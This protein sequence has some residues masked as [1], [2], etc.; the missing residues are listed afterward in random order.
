M[1]NNGINTDSLTPDISV[2][3][4]VFNN[5]GY[6]AEAIDSILQQSFSNFE[7]IIIDDASTDNSLEIIEQYATQDKRIIILRNAENIKLAA[8]L[9][10]GIN[11]ARGQYIAR[12]DSDDVAELSRLETQI[13]FMQENSDIGVSGTWVS[14]YESPNTIWKTAISNDAA[15]CSAFFGSCFHHPTVM[16]RRDVLESHGGYDEEVDFAQDSHLW[17]QLTFDHGVKFANLPEVLL[18]YRSHP[19]ASREDYRYKQQ[20]KANALRKKNLKRLGI[21]PS[22]ND[23][24]L[25]ESLCS[26]YGMKDKPGLKAVFEWVKQLEKQNTKITLLDHSAFNYELSQKLL[27]V[28]LSSAKYNLSA[29]IIYLSYTRL[30]NLP[31]NIYRALRMY[32][33]YFFSKSGGMPENLS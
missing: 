30:E 13:K 8:S 12:M 20:S 29:P 4:S 2:V 3:M 19:D 25:H 10:K 1:I 31:K 32:L 23:F 21:K 22:E 33:M 9:N 7:F 26:A 5:E 18:K 17:S 28:C 6:L 15:R 27:G 14:V 24:R 16:F 11:Q